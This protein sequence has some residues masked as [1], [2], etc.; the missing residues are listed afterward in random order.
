MY[1]YPSHL[2]FNFGWLSKVFPCVYVCVCVCVCVCVRALLIVMMARYSL[3]WLHCCPS[4]TVTQRYFSINWSQR[5]S[6]K[7][8]TS[9]PLTATGSLL[10]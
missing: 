10:H 9:D 1:T 3:V 7:E 6:A 4:L 5:L 8:V 2:K